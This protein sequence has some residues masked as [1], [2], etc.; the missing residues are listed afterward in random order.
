M[1]SI[2]KNELPSEIFIKDG[3]LLKYTPEKQKVLAIESESEQLAKYN[4]DNE[5]PIDASGNPVSYDTGLDLDSTQ[6]KTQAESRK[7]NRH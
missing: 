4:Y 5:V 2:F 1:R 7:K 3:N 6:Y